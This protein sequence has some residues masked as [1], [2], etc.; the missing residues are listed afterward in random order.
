MSLELCSG[1]LTVMRRRIF[2]EVAEQ[3][4]KSDGL[5]APAK[6][7]DDSASGQSTPPPIY[8]EQKFNQLPLRLN[9]RINASTASLDSPLLTG[10]DYNTPTSYSSSGFDPL[11][12]VTPL[13]IARRSNTS[14]SQNAVPP[15]PASS[16]GRRGRPLPRPPG[17]TVTAGYVFV[18]YL[19]F[20]TC[21]TS[22]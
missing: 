19:I 12:N 13:Y 18:P 21:L 22:S 8:Q 2:E 11:A 5:L 20:Q 1:E 9:P 3:I 4:D 14:P 10:S 15:R 17:A 6:P 7:D 16:H